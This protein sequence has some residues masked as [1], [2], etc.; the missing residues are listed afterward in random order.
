MDKIKKGLRNMSLRKSLVVLAVFCLGIVS[1]LSIITI[2]TL[3]N[4][5]QRILDTRPIIVTGYTSEYDVDIEKGVTVI[6]QEYNYGELSKEKK[7]Y[8]WIATASMVI[9][10]VLY[11]IIAS[12]IVAKF[13][14]KLK[15]QAPLENLKNGMH[16]ISEQ[17]LD[18]CMTYSSDDELGELCNSFEHMRTEVYKSNRKMWDMLGD[19]KAL[20]ASISHDLRTPITV[21]NGYID[22]LEKAINKGLLTNDVLRTTLQNMAGAA[23]R[24]QRYVDCVNDIQKIEDIEIKKECYDFKKFLSEITQEFSLMAKQHGK[25]LEI[26]DLTKS[27]FLQTDKDILCKV[28]ENI[29]DNALRFANDK[30]RLTITESEN[31]VSFAVQDDGAGFTAEELGSAVSFFYSSPTNGGNF[32]IGLSISKILCEKLGGI[33]Q[34]RN[35]SD[36]G[37]IVTI[38]IENSQKLF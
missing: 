11:I 33:L 34:L 6:P 37:A 4:I 22:Y 27:L 5:Q 20:T 19:R 38:K 8:Y 14:Y 31:C 35:S 26:Q 7:V 9:F 36:Y 12:I 18:F 25:Q 13:Y 10:P 24:L 15:L 29:F 30:I 16:H 32:G 17:N 21:I 28:L 23:G 3:S 2:L 1:I